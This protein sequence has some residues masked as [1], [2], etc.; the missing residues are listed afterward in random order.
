MDDAKE[1]DITFSPNL[2]HTVSVRSRTAPS[3][4]LRYRAQLPQYELTNFYG[5]GQINSTCLDSL[6]LHLIATKFGSSVETETRNKTDEFQAGLPL[7]GTMGI[8]TRTA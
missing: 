5:C 7:G 4:D 1:H 3:F 6:I 2:S 8:K